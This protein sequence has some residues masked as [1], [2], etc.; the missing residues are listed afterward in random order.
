ME[1]SYSIAILALLVF[2]GFLVWRFGFSKKRKGGTGT[3]GGGGG[4]KGGRPHTHKK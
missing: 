2:G 1:T 4:G 3:G